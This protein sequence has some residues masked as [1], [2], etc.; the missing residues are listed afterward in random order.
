MALVA[1]AAA[2][3]KKANAP[4][5]HV[6]SVDHGLRKDARREVRFVADTCKQLG[7]Q[8]K[9]LRNTASLGDSGIQ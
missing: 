1:L 7:L 8:H 5:F 3:L 9:I 6:V 2:C 4:D